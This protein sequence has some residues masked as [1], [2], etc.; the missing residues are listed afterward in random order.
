MTGRGIDQI[1]PHQVEPRLYEPFVKDAREYVF[2]AEKTNGKITYPVAMDYIW[3]DALLIWRQFQPDV[4]IINLETAITQAGDPWPNKGIHYRMHPLNIAVLTSAGINICALANNHLLDWGY[5][6]LKE[7]L[8]TLKSAG[9]KFSGAGENITHAMQPAIVELILNKR[10]LV[11]SA[12]T[13]SSGIP[14]AWQASAHRSGVY[15]LPDLTIKTLTHVAENIQT[16]KRSGDLII[17]SIHWGSNWGHE[18]PD[19][20]RSFAYGL[21]DIGKV[22]VVFGHSSHHPRAIEM[23]NGKPIFY[24]CGDFINDY[25]GISGYEEH[26]DDLPLMY[27]LDFDAMSLQ[28]EKMTL[29][30][31]QIKKFRLHLANKRDGDWVLKTLNE[32][33]PFSVQFDTYGERPICFVQRVR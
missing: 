26:R 24:G 11:F 12:G 10:V 18:I 6:G 1:L 4:K 13:P 2:L 28:F 9:I 20:F 15:Y 3:G 19:S 17:F 30:P 8:V 31:L 22:D 33:A 7:T 25:E 5:K 27:F 16:F 21:I 32:S 23:Y 14:S 29:I